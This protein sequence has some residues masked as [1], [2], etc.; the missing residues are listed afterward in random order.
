VT[1]RHGSVVLPVH[2]TDRVREGQVFATFHT[3]AAFVNRLT[4]PWRDEVTGTPEYKVTA[5][6][7]EPA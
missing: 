1:S 4:S 3:R 6:R 5:V 7:L 2:V